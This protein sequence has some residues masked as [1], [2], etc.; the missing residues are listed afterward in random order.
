MLS[1][2]LVQVIPRDPGTV[3][4]DCSVLLTR[5]TAHNYQ[6]LRSRHTLQGRRSKPWHG[7]ELALKP[8]NI[9]KRCENHERL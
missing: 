3:H 2:D 5:L 8:R 7:T 4:H 9:A 1:R 6:R